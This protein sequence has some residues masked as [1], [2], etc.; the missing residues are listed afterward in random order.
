MIKVRDLNEIKDTDTAWWAARGSNDPEADLRRGVSFLDWG[1]AP[2][3][4]ED[5]AREEWPEAENIVYDESA[6][7]W[8]PAHDGLCAFVGND[9][10]EALEKFLAWSG[11][12]AYKYIMIFPCRIVGECWDAD[13]VRPVG[14]V[15]L[16]INTRS[17]QKGE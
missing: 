14:T 1:L 2:E 4:T 13:I 16:I 7:G 5:A 11:S 3:A 15:Y 6:G 10:Q 17:E 8:L 12:D 9:P